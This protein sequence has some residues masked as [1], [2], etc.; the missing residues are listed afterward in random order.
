MHVWS[1]S[2]VLNCRFGVIGLHAFSTGMTVNE[3][4]TRNDTHVSNVVQFCKGRHVTYELYHI[5]IRKC[6]VGLDECKKQLDIHELIG[7]K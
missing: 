4:T 6:Y 5:L 1:S 2:S 3:Q 7:L